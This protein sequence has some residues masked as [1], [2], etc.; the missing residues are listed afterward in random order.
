MPETV[1][2]LDVREI[3]SGDP[4][5]IGKLDTVVTYQLDP[6]RTYIEMMPQEDAKDPAKLKARI[7]KAMAERNKLIGTEIEI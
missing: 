7:K 1:K 3:P 5:R 6:L 4:E 2:I